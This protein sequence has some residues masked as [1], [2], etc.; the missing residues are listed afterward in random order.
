[1]EHVGSFP[2]IGPF[3]TMLI[4]VGKGAF[5]AKCS[6]FNR[7]NRNQSRGGTAVLE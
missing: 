4:F 1:M 3:G 2:F 7:V 6:R 5:R